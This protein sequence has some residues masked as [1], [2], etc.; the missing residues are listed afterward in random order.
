MRPTDNPVASINWLLVGVTGASVVQNHERGS[1]DSRNGYDE[2][3]EETTV[4]ETVPVRAAWS[5]RDLE[6]LLSS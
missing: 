2:P 6:R 5:T 4:T 3:F 1:G